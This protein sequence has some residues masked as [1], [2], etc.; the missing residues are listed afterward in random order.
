MYRGALETKQND[1]PNKFL[2]IILCVDYSFQN[3]L[4]NLGTL[5]RFNINNMLKNEKKKSFFINS[6]LNYEKKAKTEI[7]FS[8]LYV[9]Y[10]R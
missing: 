8:N 3:R 4:N 6:I 2:F 9:L 7:C 10:F 5:Y 1:C